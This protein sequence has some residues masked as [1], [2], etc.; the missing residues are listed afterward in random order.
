VQML[1]RLID[2]Y[3]MRERPADP[4]LWHK[5][6]TA[7]PVRFIDGETSLLPHGQM[8]RRWNGEKW[9]YRAEPETEEDYRSTL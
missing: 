7:W 8:W 9:E 6:N 5:W 4:T 3:L 1:E 2:A